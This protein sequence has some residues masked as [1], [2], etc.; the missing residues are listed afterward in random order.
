L[1]VSIRH[2]TR[3][4]LAAPVNYSVQCLRLTPPSFEAQQVVSWA[5]EAPRIEEA[6][7]F[8]DSFGNICHLVVAPEPHSEMA[9][10]ARGTVE[11]RDRAGVA[12]GLVE[13]APAR[14]YK[15]ETPR[16]APDDAIRELARDTVAGDS[17]ERMHKLMDAV[18]KRVEYVIGA[19]D[20][21][22]TAAEAL[23]AGKGVCQDH[24][25]VFIS[26]ARIMGLPARYV[27]GYFL[28]DSD[29]PAEAHHAWAEVWVSGLGW[30]GFDP[31]NQ[32]CPTERYVRLACGLDS[33]S[34]A[35]IRGTRRGTGRIEESLDVLVEVQQQSVQQQQ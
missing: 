32:V 34:A 10:V 21:E 7:R 28:T 12:R 9:I 29:D 33:A 11:T 19:T 1:L 4:A 3:Y 31:A 26:A 22:T 14:V 17:I 35:P 13:I 18:H 27:N 24:A 30:V 20:P 8:R 23:N 2:V 25:H 16:T 5:L 6:I 15:R